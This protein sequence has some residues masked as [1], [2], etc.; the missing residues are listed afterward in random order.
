M[1]LLSD[2]PTR[3]RR[4]TRFERIYLGLLPSR[5]GELLDDQDRANIRKWVED[6][7][8]TSAIHEALKVHFDIGRSTVERG[9]AELEA[10][11]WKA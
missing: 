1:A 3:P 5:T 9:L 8:S 6:G 2:P 11:E 7:V 4:L 10:A